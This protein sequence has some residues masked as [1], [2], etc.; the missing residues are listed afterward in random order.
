MT[1]LGDKPEKKKLILAEVWLAKM[2]FDERVVIDIVN[3]EITITWK[4]PWVKDHD[5]QKGI[6]Q[7]RQAIWWFAKFDLYE[8]KRL[9]DMQYKRL[10]KDGIDPDPDDAFV[11]YV[12]RA[13]DKG[14]MLD[15]RRR[16]RQWYENRKFQWEASA[17]EGEAVPAGGREDVVRRVEEVQEISEAV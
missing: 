1:F 11:V 6:D 4:P 14:N 7:H 3:D 16:I 8:C 15:Y 10:E 13:R 17:T 9:W 5:I 12:G 2:Q